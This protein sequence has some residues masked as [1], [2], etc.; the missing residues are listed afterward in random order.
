[1]VVAVVV[2]AAIIGQGHEKATDAFEGHSYP[3]S[4]FS[5]TGSIPKGPPDTLK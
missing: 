2:V 1:V 3:F 5:L 4:D